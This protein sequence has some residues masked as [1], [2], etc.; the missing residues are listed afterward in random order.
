M[1]TKRQYQRLMSEFKKTGKIGVSAM[2]SNMH[3][4]TAKKYINEGKCP[5]QLQKPHLWRTRKDP[6][7][8]VWPKVEPMLEAAPE[9]EAKTLFEHFLNTPGSGLEEKHLRTFY[10]RV[11]HWKA[12]R[13]KDK[14]VYFEQN[15]KP[16]ELMQLDW[17]YSKDLNVTI[18]GEPLDHVFCHCVLP[19]SNWQWTTRCVSESFMSLKSGFQAAVYELGACPE[20]LCTDNTSAATHELNTGS[21]P[22]RGYNSDYLELC[23]HYDV[24]PISINVNCPHEHGDVESLNGHFKRRLNQ[25]LLLRGSRD[26]KSLDA[27]D[28]FVK[29]INRGANLKRQSKVAEEL[30]VMRPLPESRLAEYKEYEVPVSSN[31]LIR[32]GK[33]SYSVPSRLI[34]K[35]VRVHLFENHLKVYL[36]REYL[37]DLPRNRG[38]RNATVDFRHVIGSLIRKPGA[39]NNYRH[40]ESL[41]PSLTFRKAYDRL[42]A[43]HGQ[44]PGTIEYLHLLKLAAEQSVEAVEGLLIGFLNDKA[45]WHAVD[46]REQL[47]GPVIHPMEIVMPEPTL[48]SYDNLLGEEVA[49][50]G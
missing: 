18:E 20:H 37:L 45:R 32:I 28:R 1:I 4:Q 41:Y 26:F 46:L 23:T 48:E 42:I 8:H 30:A 34:G 2:M 16:G 40:R 14:E 44:R 9:L 15:R 19:Y 27:Y 21:Y 36:G 13:G 5:D 10:R 25:H 29:E 50:V 47:V 38:E 39:F 24:T 7:E 43:D 35:K 17:T 31:S 12:T 22:R 11:S 49:D 3:P 33:R 6:L